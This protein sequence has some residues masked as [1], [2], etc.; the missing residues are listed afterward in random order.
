MK[1]AGFPIMLTALCAFLAAPAL[2]APR[3]EAF[4]GISRCAALSDDRALLDCIY[5]AAQ[6]LRAELGLPPAPPEQIHQVP[7]ELLPTQPQD[8]VAIARASGALHMT[9]YGFD[10]NGHFT[11]TISNGETWRQSHDDIK[12]ARWHG[13]ATD[14]AVSLTK[15]FFGGYKL[16]VQ[17]DPRTY[18]VQP[19][20]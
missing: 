6:P 5:G 7:P 18:F 14:Y 3:D 8:A 4:A 20:R 10:S 13:K 2:A 19:V 17:G 9:S 12:L 15:D 1:I 16:K 11:V